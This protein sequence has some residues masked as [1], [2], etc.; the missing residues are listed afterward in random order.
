MAGDGEGYSGP[1]TIE[2]G[3]TEV[4]VQAV[5]RGQFDPIDGR[6]HWYG[7]LVPNAD[8][9]ALVARAPVDVRVVTPEGESFGK[10]GDADMWGR[11]RVAGTGRPPFALLTL[12]EVSDDRLDP[13]VSG[14]TSG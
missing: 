8:L 10:M 3:N 13:A 12:D 6:Y 9:D 11:L 1:V 5:L 2:A 7:R 14:R 4:R